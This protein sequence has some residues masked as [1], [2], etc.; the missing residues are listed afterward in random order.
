LFVADLR[1]EVS[2]AF[3]QIEASGGNWVDA[4]SLTRR[5]A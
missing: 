1:T 4:D 2:A 5:L 3:P